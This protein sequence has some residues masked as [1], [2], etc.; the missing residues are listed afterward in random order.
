M[1]V[2]YVPTTIENRV[3][4][5]L[6][7]I[8]CSVAFIFVGPSQLLAFKESLFLMGLGQALVGIFSSILIVPGL[9]EM[10]E[11][12]LI[13]HPNQENEVNNLSSGIFN[14]ALGIGQILAPTYGSIASTALGFRLTTDIVSIVCL[15][16]GVIYFILGNGLQAFVDTHKNLRGT[17]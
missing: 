1:A 9:P 11:S 16:F 3:L 5:I 4:I 12:A 15:F 7:S 13:E 17:R 6:A 8:F 10:I 14:A 2:Q